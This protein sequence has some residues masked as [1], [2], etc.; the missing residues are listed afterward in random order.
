M[1]DQLCSITI[2]NSFFPMEN[3]SCDHFIVYERAVW[4]QWHRGRFIAPT[5]AGNNSWWVPSAPVPPRTLEQW[6]WRKNGGKNTTVLAR[7][8]AGLWPILKG[9]NTS[10]I[11][12][13]KVWVHHPLFE[14]ISGRFYLRTVSSRGSSCPTLNQLIKIILC[15]LV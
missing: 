10:F 3:V 8:G 6:P 15:T 4:S 13:N 14:H 2:D 1:K 5:V 7:A 12:W 9:I 11:N